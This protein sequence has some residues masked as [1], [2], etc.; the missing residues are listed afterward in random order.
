MAVDIELGVTAV[1]GAAP[2]DPAMHSSAA[3]RPHSRSR[4]NTVSQRGAPAATEHPLRAHPDQQHQHHHEFDFDD[5]E[6]DEDDRERESDEAANSCVI[7]PDG[8]FRLRWVH[9]WVMVV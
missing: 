6:A 7:K 5:F 8:V 9:Y 3:A 2:A 1:R 4:R